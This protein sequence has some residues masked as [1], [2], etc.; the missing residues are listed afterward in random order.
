MDAVKINFEKYIKVA[1]ESFFAR[2]GK[3]VNV[4]GLTIESMGPDARLGDVCFVYPDDTLAQ[5]IMTEVVGFKEGKTQLMPYGST[6]GIGIGNIVVNTERPLTVQVSD[7]LLG[8]TLDGLGRP[9][10]EHIL[11]RH[12]LRIPCQER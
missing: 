9:T 1:E 2:K 12:R 8:K 3:I 7:A 5:P 10:E 6:E 11:L 4:V